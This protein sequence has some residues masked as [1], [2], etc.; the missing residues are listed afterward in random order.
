R[1]LISVTTTAAMIHTNSSETLTA[2]FVIIDAAS[3]NVG[4]VVGVLKSGAAT[5][6]VTTVAARISVMSNAL[7]ID[8]PRRAA[9]KQNQDAVDGDEWHGE[10]KRA[11]RTK[12]LIRERRPRDIRLHVE[13][14]RGQRRDSRRGA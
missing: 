10:H 7:R 4:G 14:D 11:E 8:P 12:L 6:A 5:S 1:A 13:R 2:V 9:Q 3:P